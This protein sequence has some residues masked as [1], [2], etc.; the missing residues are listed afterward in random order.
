MSNP[1][2][3]VT[4]AADADPSLE[5]TLIAYRSECLKIGRAL[6]LLRQAEEQE[7]TRPR[8]VLEVRRALG[9][10]EKEEGK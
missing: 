1:Y 4:T 2:R 7:W 8:L 10:P 5:A 9:A 3:P 6:R